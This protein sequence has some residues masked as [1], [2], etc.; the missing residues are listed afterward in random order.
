[1]YTIEFNGCYIRQFRNRKLALGFYRKKLDE[2][3]PGED[4][5]RLWY[6]GIVILSNDNEIYN[7]EET[8]D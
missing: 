3:V 4:T 8:E 2:A 7:C 5:V 6:E 1:M